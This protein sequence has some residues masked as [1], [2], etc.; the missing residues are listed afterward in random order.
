MPIDLI[1][2]RST[3]TGKYPEMRNVTNWY[4]KLDAFHDL[5]EKWVDGLENDPTSRNFVIKSIREFLE[6]PVAYIKREQLDLLGMIKDKLPEYTLTDE[7][8]KPS[9]TLTLIMS[10]KEKKPALPSQIITS[11]TGPGRL[12]CRSD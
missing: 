11:V 9:V 7:A 6:P 4:F 3:L 2:P 5:L 10:G 1:N 8:N 12:W